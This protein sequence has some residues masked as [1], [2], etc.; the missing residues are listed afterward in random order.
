MAKRIA[1]PPKD[2][3]LRVVGPKAVFKASRVQNLSM[4]KDIPTNDVR[5]LG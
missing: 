4:T 2:T 1:I 3:Q 5:E